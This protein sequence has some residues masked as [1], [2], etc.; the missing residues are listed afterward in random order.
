MSA[1]ASA[2]RFD[3][4]ALR[5]FNGESGKPVYLALKGKVFDV[6]SGKSF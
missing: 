1:P 4:A 3:A 2:K 6:T 5:P